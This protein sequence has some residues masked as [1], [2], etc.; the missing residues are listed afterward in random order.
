MYKLVGVL[1]GL[2]LLISCAPVEPEEA[3]KT[4]ES[5]ELGKHYTSVSGPFD[6]GGKL[7]Y[8]A[9]IQAPQHPNGVQSI[10][11]FDG[12]E[13]G[14]EYDGAQK[15]VDVGGKLA[16]VALEWMKQWFIVF[17]GQELSRE[18]AQLGTFDIV[19]IN[20][21]PGFT[22]TYTK[23]GDSLFVLGDKEIG[24]GY[25][26]T[27]CF[28]AIDD[29][30]ACLAK[31]KN[32]IRRRVLFGGSEVGD[33]NDAS[34]PVDL[35]SGNW[36]DAGIPVNLNGKVAFTVEKN[37]DWYVVI[38]GVEKAKYD[39]IH[40]I[41]VIDGKLVVVASNGDGRYVDYD[42]KKG[43]T[44]DI[45]SK[46]TSVNGK[47]VYEAGIKRY[48]LVVAPE[49]PPLYDLFIVFDGKEITK[50][51]I[52]AFSPV[53]VGGKLAYKAKTHKNSFIVFDGKDYEKIIKWRL[54]RCYY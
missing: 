11:V 27:S 37:D 5:V 29:K 44:Y 32:S 49:Q 51:Y 16:Y 17:D 45:I 35:H 12:V 54:F 43:K 38:D 21:E 20:G 46:F 33:W 40:Y 22:A 8:E 10:I 3:V 6:I 31:L 25:Q 15:P 2:A 9:E 28:F 13:H 39:Y 36:N 42:G 23:G 14:K 4:Y 26:A 53:N 50:Q 24:E 34:I 47:L 18:Y 52:D 19:D 1:I 7:A 48:T 30:L 41:E